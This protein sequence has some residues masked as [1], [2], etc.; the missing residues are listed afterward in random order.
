[1]EK[2]SIVGL[3]LVIFA[4]TVGSAYIYLLFFAG[5]AL[6]LLILKITALLTVGSFLFVILVIGF[7]LLISPPTVKIEEMERKLAEELRKLKEKGYPFP[8]A[9]QA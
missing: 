3:I 7:S 5:E 6:S 8:W 1:M 9:E 4:L 2:D